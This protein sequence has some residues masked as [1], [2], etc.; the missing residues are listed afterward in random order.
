MDAAVDVSFE[1]LFG[2]PPSAEE[3]T[4]A[5]H[6]LAQAKTSFSRAPVR[7]RATLDAFQEVAGFTPGPYLKKRWIQGAIV[8]V[9]EFGENATELLKRSV[10]H[11]RNQKPPLTIKSPISCIV[12]AHNIKAGVFD[13]DSDLRRQRYVIDY[14]D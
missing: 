9:E 4:E 2:R 5:L 3:K 10:T 13:S 11:M 12:T 8:W 7:T 14:G 1:K 6:N